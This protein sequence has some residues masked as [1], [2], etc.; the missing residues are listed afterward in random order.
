MNSQIQINDLKRQR[1]RLERNLE[2]FEK[3]FETLEKNYEKV[4]KEN[5]ELE[6]MFKE[7]VIGH[8]HVLEQ[9]ISLS[10]IIKLLTDYKIEKGEK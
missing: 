5:A 4:L 7:L 6:K 1:D 10:R 8:N 2:Y 9:T 3:N